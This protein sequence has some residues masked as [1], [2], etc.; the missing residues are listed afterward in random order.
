MRHEWL[1]PKLGLTMTEGALVEWTL[2]PGARFSA[3]D[4]VFVVENDKAAT[5]VAAESDGVMGA[6]L[7]AVGG[8]LITVDPLVVFF[9][10][11]AMLAGW[12][13]IT[14]DSTAWWLACSSA[15]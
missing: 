14:R 11:L 15:P 3:G 5:E 2:A 7:V 10:S 8:I 6:P 4:C 1:M 12:R 13:A 9:W